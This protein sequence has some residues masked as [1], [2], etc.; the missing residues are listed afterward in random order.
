MT[1]QMLKAPLSGVI[2]VGFMSLTVPTLYWLNKPVAARPLIATVQ[3]YAKRFK[4]FSCGRV[5][6]WF[7]GPSGVRASRSSSILQVYVFRSRS[8]FGKR[9]DEVIGGGSLSEVQTRV[10]VRISSCK[11][12]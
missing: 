11:F 1:A 12:R 5:I 7:V 2:S 9:L 3:M 4:V 8:I 6:E 10:V